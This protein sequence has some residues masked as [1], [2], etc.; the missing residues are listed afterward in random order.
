MS[1]FTRLFKST[2]PSTQDFTP[3][4]TRPEYLAVQ[5]LIL[6]IADRSKTKP[7]YE[8]TD[9]GTYKFEQ[10]SRRVE[11]RF[12]RPRE[13]SFWHVSVVV[14]DSL[15]CSPT[16]TKL[17]LT[18][19]E[20]QILEDTYKQVRDQLYRE[21]QVKLSH[22]SQDAALDIVEGFIGDTSED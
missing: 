13:T 14:Y 11:V 2:A 8:D 12:T 22:R 9:I 16:P 19:R 18:P 10:K 1:I 20:A 3:P 6:R 15:T 4:H 5:F 7:S 21:E 17:Q